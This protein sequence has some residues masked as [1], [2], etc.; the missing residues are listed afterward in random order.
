MPTKSPV[1]EVSPLATRA[2]LRR[3]RS[4]VTENLLIDGEFICAHYAECFASR[5]SGDDFREGT[6]THVGRR[7]DLRLDGRPLRIVVVGQESGRPRD[8]SLQ[9]LVDLDARYQQVHGR[10]GLQR[11]YY[12][13]KDAPGRNP[14]MRG[15]TSALRL[16][17][18]AGLGTS[19][20]DEFI[21]PVNGKAFH[22][23]DGFALVNRL[24]CSAG[25]LGT[26]QGRPTPTMFRNCG[27]HFTATLAILKP[28][29]LIVQGTAVA[30]GVNQVIP[31][32]QVHD[33]HLH[34]A[35]LGEDRMVVCTFSHPSAHGSQRWGD[36]LDAPYLTDVVAPTLRDALGLL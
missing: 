5:G 17:L 15:T 28:T 32:T 24:L 20:D 18:G 30:K 13:D 23:F 8:P 1:I 36:R 33:E 4:Y 3:L 11:R 21:K 6:M 29:L 19:F 10:A 34:E 27:Q 12:T 22:I 26:S 25:P 9:Q 14:H 31:V 16:L 7:F 2:R 35:R